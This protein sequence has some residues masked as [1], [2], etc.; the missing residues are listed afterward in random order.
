MMND[1]IK[2]YKRER[3]RILRAKRSLEK[4]GFKLQVDIPKIPKK[5][6]AGSVRRLQKMT[7]RSLQER[8]VKVDNLTGEIITARQQKVRRAK[9]RG[10]SRSIEYHRKKYDEQ[11]AL[12]K[13]HAR[14]EEEERLER[15]RIE[16]AARRA[17]EAEESARRRAWEESIA[18]QLET[19]EEDILDEWDYL[20]SEVWDEISQIPNK[21][22]SY[23]RKTSP[24]K[25]TSDLRTIQSNIANAFSRFLDGI[26]PGAEA[27]EGAADILRQ[28]LADEWLVT[29]VYDS[30][31]VL[32]SK[33]ANYMK[34]ADA[35]NSN[36]LKQQLQEAAE[37]EL[38]DDE[39]AWVELSQ[40][41][42]QNVI[43]PEGW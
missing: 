40:E 25:M 26:Q 42:M 5:I 11:K 41:A 18:G 27:R 37:E 15:Q 32:R 16:E 4:Q 21:S 10:R 7:T 38:T 33:Y 12:E 24:K 34:F 9:A 39:N 20:I 31:D 35:I 6:T 28:I 1:T 14:I 22:I 23:S 29:Q 2:A 19:P 36:T 8:A 13:L 30:G 3:N 17:D 43:L